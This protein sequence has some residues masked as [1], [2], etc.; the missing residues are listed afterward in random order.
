MKFLES[1]QF[2]TVTTLLVMGLSCAGNPPPHA[3]PLVI[4]N[5]GDSARMEEEL[6]NLVREFETLAEAARRNERSVLEESLPAIQG[7]LHRWQRRLDSLDIRRGPGFQEAE[8]LAF[9]S[10]L[11]TLDRRLNAALDDINTALRTE[12][13]AP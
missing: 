12:A 8:I 13:P 6:G 1:C 4:R 3:D 7:Q 9:Q 11:E 10:R 2:L 5:T